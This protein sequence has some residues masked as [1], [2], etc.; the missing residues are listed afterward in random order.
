MALSV[1]KDGKIVEKHLSIDETTIKEVISGTDRTK[2]KKVLLRASK[3]KI[4]RRVAS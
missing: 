1:D 2:H 3:T 4:T